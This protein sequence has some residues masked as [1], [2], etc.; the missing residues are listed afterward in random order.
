MTGWVKRRSTRTT[1][2][3]SCLSLTTT[4]WS[5]RFG[6][7]NLL[8]FR[9]RA[10]CALAFGYRL[11]L[12]RLRRLRLTGALLR[13]DGLDAGDIAPHLAHAR[14][15]FELAGRT[16]K[17]Q[18]EL[19]LLQPQRFVVELVDGHRSCITRLH[20]QLPIIPRCARQSAS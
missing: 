16:L 1:T 9:F 3:L 10:R 20:H 2:V 13:R 4:P 6:I 12:L 11:R 7:L 8:L 17:A 19:L 14:R 15:I 5:V 18:V